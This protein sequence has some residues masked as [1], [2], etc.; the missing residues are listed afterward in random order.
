M[1]KFE[2]VYTSAVTLAV[3]LA[4][5]SALA[6]TPTPQPVP[7]PTPGPVNGIPEPSMLGLMAIG[8]VGALMAARKRK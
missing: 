6:G 3:V 1:T 4:S 5:A 7:I 8:V 2:K